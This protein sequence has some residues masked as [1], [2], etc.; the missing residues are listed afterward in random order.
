MGAWPPLKGAGTHDRRR[1]AAAPFSHAMYEFFR[2][3]FDDMLM[4]PEIAPFTVSGVVILIVIS[5]AATL[6][7]GE[8]EEE[9][10]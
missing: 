9:G 6:T 2:A 10:D 3:L 8:P 5:L 7:G 4:A 1:G